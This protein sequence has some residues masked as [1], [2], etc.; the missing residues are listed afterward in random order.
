MMGKRLP[1][2]PVGGSATPKSDEVI[3]ML[4]RSG[5]DIQRPLAVRDG[6]GAPVTC[7]SCGCRLFQTGEAWFHFNPLGGRDARG[8][9]VACADAAHDATGRPVSIAV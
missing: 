2:T 4:H 6:A 7:S 9:R 1:G 8:C 5:S 3:A